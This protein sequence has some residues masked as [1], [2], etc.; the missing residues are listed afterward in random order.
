V[1]RAPPDPIPSR[2]RSS[3]KFA[4]DGLKMREC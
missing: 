1:V 2:S 4:L 3:R